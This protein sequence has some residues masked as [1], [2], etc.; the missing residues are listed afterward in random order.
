VTQPTIIACLS[1]ALVIA[2]NT[3]TAKIAGY[4]EFRRGDTV[5]VEG[6]RV[7]ATASTT[8]KGAKSLAANPLGYEVKVTGHRN[9]A[10]VLI[11]QQVEAKANGRSDTERQT[12]VLLP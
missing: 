11:A 3:P 8:F 9:D 1:A 7:V 4:A 5:M 10:G 2:G 12:L 6:Q